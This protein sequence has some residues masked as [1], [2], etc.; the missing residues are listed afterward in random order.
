MQKCCADF[1]FILCSPSVAGALSLES[2]GSMLTAIMCLL[3]NAVFRT[4]LNKIN[5]SVTKM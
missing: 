5:S 2:E 4:E 1:F 3:H